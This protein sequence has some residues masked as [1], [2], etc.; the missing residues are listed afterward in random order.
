MDNPEL[1]IKITG[2]TSR[3]GDAE[4]NN[5]LSLNRANDIGARIMQKAQ[6]LGASADVLERL[7]SQI[8]TSG[9]GENRAIE[10]GEA[11]GTDNANDRSTTVEYSV[12]GI[13]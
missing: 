13:E 7:K 8:S 6:E 2:H 4:Y 3:K 12:K 5:E 10:R 11:D 1:N 9:G